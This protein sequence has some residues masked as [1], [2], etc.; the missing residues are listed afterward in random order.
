LREIFRIQ[1]DNE[2]GS[3]SFSASAEGI[4]SW[5]GRDVWKSRGRNMFRLFAQEIDYL[6]DEWA[7]D[8]QPSQDSFVFQKNLITH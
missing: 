7:P 4:V 6:P 2:I 5:I 1:R 3:A 8:A